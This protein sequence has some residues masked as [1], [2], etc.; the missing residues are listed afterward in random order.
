MKGLQNLGNTCYFNSALQCMLQIPQLSNY[1]ITNTYNG[2]CEFTK[3]YSEVVKRMWLTKAPSVENPETLLGLLRETFKVFDNSNEHDCQEAFLHMLDILEKDMPDVIKKLLYSNMIHTTK[4]KSGTSVIRDSTCI[5]LLMPTKSGDTL[6]G[7]LHAQQE[8][9]VF[10][11][12]ED[13]DGVKHNVAASRTQF[14]S[15][16][17]ILVFSFAMYD[18]KKR[19]RVGENLDMRPFMTSPTN[20][21]RYVLFGT[22]VHQGVSGKGHYV[23]YTKHKGQW[24]RKDD[25]VVIKV[26]EAPL[27]ECHYLVFYKH[28]RG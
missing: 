1:V 23:A 3:E 24:Y 14:E 11:D 20:D 16:P 13:N 8:W 22:C 25:E 6:T 15:A 10:R 26:R 27:T 7:L 19:I 9:S 17:P 2:S 18:A 5:H 28:V 4:C 21:D 12:Y